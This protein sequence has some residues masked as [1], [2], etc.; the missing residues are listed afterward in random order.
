MV[1]MRRYYGRTPAPEFGPKKL[2]ML[3]DEMIRGDAMAD[4]PR[5]PWSRKYINQQI[6]R[7]RRVF[8]WAVSQEILRPEVHQALCTVEPLKRGRSEARE[9]PKV[10]PARQELIDAV[11]PRLN[12][13]VGAMVQLQLLSGARSGE[14][15]QIRRCDIEIDDDSGIWTY[16]PDKHKNVHREMERVIYFG[17]RAQ[18]ILLKFF[19]KRPAQ[20]YLFSPKE[21]EK[22]RRAELGKRRR[23][24]K[25]CGNRPGTNRKVDPEISPHDR[26]AT[27]SYRRAIWYGCDKAFPPPPPFRRQEGET[28]DQWWKRLKAKKLLGQLNEWRSRLRPFNHNCCHGC[29]KRFGWSSKTKTPVGNPRIFPPTPAPSRPR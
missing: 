12:R 21:A 1:L 10:L 9:N 14:L 7:I 29:M 28:V 3:R 16:R 18:A 11:L 23:T 6:Q 15:V 25:S 24:P 19:G 13:Q 5:K 22:E 4:P 17:P 27:D 8:K 20:A 2:R 26:Y